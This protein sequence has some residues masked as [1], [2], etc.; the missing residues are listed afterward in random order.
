M[1]TGF[2]YFSGT[3]KIK[4]YLLLFV[5]KLK[6]FISIFAGLALK[7]HGQLSI[8]RDTLCSA[9]LPISWQS[10]AFFPL[11]KTTCKT[12][13]PFT[14][15]V[16]CLNAKIQSKSVYPINKK[17]LWGSASNFFLQATFRSEVYSVKYIRGCVTI[18]TVAW[19]G[20]CI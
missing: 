5:L 3:F 2:C 7:K 16:L 13:I 19:A 11:Q 9:H 14:S 4:V 17:H 10:R 12:K 8:M 15:K 20:Y 18:F 6:K 1:S